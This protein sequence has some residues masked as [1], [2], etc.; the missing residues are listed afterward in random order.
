MHF[1]AQGF[2]VLWANF[3]APSKTSPNSETQNVQKEPV[4]GAFQL[5]ERT[6]AGTHDMG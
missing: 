3:A 4:F 1:G 2:A 6:P 5:P